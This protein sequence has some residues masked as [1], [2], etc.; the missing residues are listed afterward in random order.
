MSLYRGGS[1]VEKLQGGVLAKSW[2]DEAP[3][4]W[5]SSALLLFILVGSC[6]SEG[7]W[8]PQE[9]SSFDP[10]CPEASLSLL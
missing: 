3:A 5:S 4:F 8:L 1:G 9:L 6:P 10:P 2:L 7:V